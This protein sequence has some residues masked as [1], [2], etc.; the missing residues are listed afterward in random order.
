MRGSLEGT[1]SHHL[2][3]ASRFGRLRRS[4]GTSMSLAEVQKMEIRIDIEFNEKE[5]RISSFGIPQTIE[6]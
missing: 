2:G 4:G 1:E 3:R 5:E 6:L